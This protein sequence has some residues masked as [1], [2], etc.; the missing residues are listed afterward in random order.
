MDIELTK[1]SPHP[2]NAEI[3]DS[4][5]GAEWEEFLRSI[6]ENGILEPLLINPQNIII[7]GHRRW[8]AAIELTL[9]TVPCLVLNQMSELEE[10]RTIVEANRYRKK[11]LHEIRHEAELLE[12]VE[13]KLATE[14]MSI[15]GSS[16]QSVPEKGRSADKIAKALG[17]GSYVT[18]DRLKKIWMVADSEPAIA[19]ALAKVDTGQKS[20]N[21]V[22]KM[23]QK[24]IYGSEKEDEFGLDLQVYD[25]WYFAEGPDPRFGIN[26]P[27][28]L[29]GQLI[30][31]VLHYWTNPGDLVVDP[32]SGG[33]VTWDVCQAMDR[34]CLA[35]DLAPVRE[36]ITQHN[37]SDGFPEECQGAQMIFLDPPYSSMLLEAYLA[38]SSESAAG[39]SYGGFI[40]FIQKLVVDAFNTLESGGHCA[41]IIMRQRSKLPV[42]TPEGT[43]F[44]DWPYLCQK[45]MDYAGFKFV[46]HVVET[47]PT[48]IYQ[49]YD[50]TIA[51]SNKKM[52]GICGSLIV[53]RKP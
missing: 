21:S 22:W 32:F 14:R 49:P 41:L 53:G 10:L 26:H 35:Y 13:T 17:I 40:E 42:G 50:V 44:I 43:T 23:T 15:G 16:K 39:L 46:E 2:K 45:A 38:L 5:K 27:G 6:K 12:E 37:I 30:Q 24:F 28:R 29:P 19:E 31:N 9:V 11:L 36:E 25:K 48:S 34:V 7:S 20:L 51:K 33:G 3:Y 4:P 8:Q 1:L 18:Y 47:W 52:L